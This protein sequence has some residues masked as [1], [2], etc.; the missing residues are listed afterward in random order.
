MNAEGESEAILRFERDVR[1]GPLAARVEDVETDLL[2][3]SGRFTGFVA[4]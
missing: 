1:R 4:L 2:E 3:P